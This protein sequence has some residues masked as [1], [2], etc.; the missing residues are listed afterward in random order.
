MANHITSLCRS[1]SFHL[2]QLR[3]V[4]SSITLDAAKAL[5]HA[6]INVRL[7]YC[8]SLL[9]GIGDGLLKKLQTVQNSAMRV[10]TGTRRFDHITP[11]LRNLCWLPV[12]Q[13]IQFKLAM[14]IFKCLH[15]LVSSYLAADRIS[16]I[17]IITVAS[18]RCLHTMKL[19]VQRTRTVIGLASSILLYYYYY[20]YTEARNEKLMQK[21]K[22]WSRH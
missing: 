16:R 7:D 6:F 22:V 4:W 14:I 18:G 12:R 2:G 5:L 9:Y 11:V 15:G 20:Y 21:I 17:S 3:F 10:V 1:R 19:S 13:R 8:N